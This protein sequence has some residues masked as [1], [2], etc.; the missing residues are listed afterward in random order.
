[1]ESSRLCKTYSISFL[2]CKQIGRRQS[3]KLKV[4]VQ[5]TSQFRKSISTE[6]TL[7]KGVEELARP[8]SFFQFA[9]ISNQRSNRVKTNIS[10]LNLL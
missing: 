9:D 7:P 1:M 5:L 10:C 2:N 4:P 6:V 8:T 3:Q